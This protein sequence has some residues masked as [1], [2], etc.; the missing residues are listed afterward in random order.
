[1]VSDI[2]TSKFLMIM[3]PVVCI[4]GSPKAIRVLYSCIIYGHQIACLSHFGC[5]L[6]VPNHIWM[7]TN[8]LQSIL[9]NHNEDPQNTSGTPYAIGPTIVAEFCSILFFR[10]R[11]QVCGIVVRGGLLPTKG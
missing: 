10:C 4:P 6:P 3:L 8:Q 5:Q 7:T 2:D 9:L 11:T 1:M